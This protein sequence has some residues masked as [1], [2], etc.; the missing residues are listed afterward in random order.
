MKYFRPGN[1]APSSGQYKVVDAL[2]NYLSAE[3]T[4]SKGE[5]FPPWYHGDLNL[6]GNYFYVLVD[7]T[8][9]LNRR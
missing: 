6:G 5:K 7:L 1:I 3:I 9:H 8:I 2:G 4:L